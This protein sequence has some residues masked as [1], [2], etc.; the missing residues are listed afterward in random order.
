VTANTGEKGGGGERGSLDRNI[1]IA[2]LL[3]YQLLTALATLRPTQGTLSWIQGDS[4]LDTGGLFPGYRGIPLWRTH[5]RGGQDSFL[6][7]Q[8]WRH[9]SSSYPLMNSFLPLGRSFLTS[10]GLIPAHSSSRPVNLRK[11]TYSCLTSFLPAYPEGPY[12]CPREFSSTNRRTRR[13]GSSFV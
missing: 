5:S 8:E 3:S 2:S 7:T 11:G 12:S 10:G 6:S 9:S 1:L 4:F 13:T